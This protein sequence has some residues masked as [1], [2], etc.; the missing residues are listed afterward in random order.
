MASARTAVRLDLRAE[1]DRLA[2]ERDSIVRDFEAA[3][4]RAG[5][6]ASA[7]TGARTARHGPHG[8]ASRRSRSTR[9]SSW[10]P[11][12][13]GSRARLLERVRLLYRVGP[14]SYNRLLLT[15]DSSQEALIATIRSS[16]TW[17]PAI[18]ISSPGPY[19]T[20]LA[21]LQEARESLADTAAGLSDEV[22][23][24]T[25]AASRRSPSSRWSGSACSR[26]SI[27]RPRHSAWRS[28]APRNAAYGAAPGT[29]SELA[30]ADVEVGRELPRGP[31]PALLVAGRG[32]HR[33]GV[34]APAPSHLRHLHGVARHRDRRRPR[35]SRDRRA[36]RPGGVYADWYSGY[37]LLVIVDHGGGY[38]T[39]YG[40]LANVSVRVNDQ[41]DR[42]V[43]RQGRGDRLAD[44]PQPVL[45]GPRGRR[46]P[47]PTS[48]LRGR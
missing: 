48:W 40:H 44:R 34:R 23:A 16:P 43:D 13:T 24:D 14:L 33:H 8:T 15:A 26:G 1:L 4:V 30:V 27:A 47:Q 10:R 41:V 22:Q 21:D 29:M 42:P 32:R 35:R 9:S 3:D 36:P 19:A 31:R 5:A 11:S 45:R 12:S 20:T 2:S 7:V 38:F 37:G 18:A 17:R 28:R 25:A 6:K 46:R 39:L